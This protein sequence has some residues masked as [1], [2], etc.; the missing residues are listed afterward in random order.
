VDYVPSAVQAL[1][2][3]QAQADLEHLAA[4]PTER[5]VRASVVRAAWP[6]LLQ[7]L[8]DRAAGRAAGKQAKGSSG[9]R[10]KKVRPAA[11]A[12]SAAPAPAAHCLAWPFCSWLH[13]VDACLLWLL[14]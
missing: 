4:H 2:Q 14:W 9:G 6:G 3:A 8:A 13:E 12:A 7:A 11:P 10:R 1:G 5:H